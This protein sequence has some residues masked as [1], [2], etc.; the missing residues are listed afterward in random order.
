MSLNYLIVMLLNY[1][2]V[3][4]NEK[5]LKMKQELAG[6]T[7]NDSQFNEVRSK[8]FLKRFG[9][10]RTTGVA[11]LSG[12]TS[13]GHTSESRFRQLEARSILHFE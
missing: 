3:M 13:V 11:L 6:T 4:L 5:H 8:F 10:Y 12:L 9:S 7:T 1:L 2:I